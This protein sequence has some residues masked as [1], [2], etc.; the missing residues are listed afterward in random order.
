MIYLNSR[1]FY[2]EQDFREFVEWYFQHPSETIKQN[3]PVRE[4]WEEAVVDTIANKLAD[5]V[6]YYADYSNPVDA[7]LFKLMWC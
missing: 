5:G 3:F 7:A 2:D 1:F 6:R 4:K